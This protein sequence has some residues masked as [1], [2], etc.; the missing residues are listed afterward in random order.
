MTKIKNKNFNLE[1][2][3]T[4]EITY[5][6]KIPECI[7]PEDC[8]ID[9]TKLTYI[10]SLLL[11]KYCESIES[12]DIDLSTID[13]SCLITSNPSINIPS[14]ITID[15]LLSFYKDHFCALYTD[16]EDVNTVLESLKGIYCIND[17]VQIDQNE[18]I[19]IDPLFNDLLN[20][21]TGIVTITI[22]TSPINGTASTASNQI[23]YTPD[24]DFFGNDQITYQVTKGSY[25]CIAKISIRVNEIITNQTITDIVNLQITNILTSNEFWDIGIPIG[26]KM[27]IT[28]SNL[29]YFNLLGVNWGNG[30]PTT[31]WSKWSICNGNNGTDDEKGL[32]TRGFDVN[33]SDYNDTFSSNSGGSD[34]ITLNINNIPPHRHLIGLTSV[35]DTGTSQSISDL[36][37]KILAD[38]KDITN[39]QAG[40]RISRNW[41]GSGSDFGDSIVWAN[42]GDGSDNNADEDELP[43]SPSAIN[44]RNAYFTEIKIQKIL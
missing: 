1:I 24:L 26:T 4:D 31:K 2:F 32:T 29:V 5:S 44:I 21:V 43:I 35:N 7:I 30:L 27:S 19:V 14:E 42:S 17:I 38:N 3:S 22:L 41:S 37:G 13:L 16:I 12:P 34:S 11:E 9:K 15:T 25:S 18:T 39:L 20:E 40:D 23:T 10:I 8:I 6:G 33:N 36:E 28:E